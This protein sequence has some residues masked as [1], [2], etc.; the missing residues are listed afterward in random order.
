MPILCIPKGGHTF[1][2]QC[3]TDAF[4]VS[5]NKYGAWS[6]DLHGDGQKVVVINDYGFNVCVS[7]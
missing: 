5:F 3:D 7:K 6:R 2:T 4:Y 1:N